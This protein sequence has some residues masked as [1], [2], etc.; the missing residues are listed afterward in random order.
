MNTTIFRFKTVAAIAIVLLATNSLKAATLFENF[1]IPSVAST[2][3]SAKD[4]TYPSGVWNVCAVTK[5][6][7]ATENDRINGLYSMRMRGLAS[8]NFMFMKFDKAGA[9]VLTPAA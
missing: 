7:T 8:Q 2:N 6:T 9:G 4:I 1:D 5:P 3:N